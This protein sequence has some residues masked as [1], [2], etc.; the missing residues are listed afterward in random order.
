MV[1]IA[2]FGRIY[3]FD[4]KED[5]LE[6]LN[7]WYVDMDS[8]ED[9]YSQLDRMIWEVKAGNT[10][11]IFIDEYDLDGLNPNIPQDFFND[12]RP[13]IRIH[14]FDETKEFTDKGDAI[15]WLEE[16][17]P[18]AKDLDM[19]KFMTGNEYESDRIKMNIALIER[20]V[21]R[22]VGWNGKIPE[23]FYD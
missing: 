15:R 6:K 14:M 9:W 1:K 11:V 18:K 23:G 2:V 8:G 3:E 12:G 4:T 21:T 13:T 16:Q 20:G 7:S 19:D 10:R 17:I 22:L 5:A